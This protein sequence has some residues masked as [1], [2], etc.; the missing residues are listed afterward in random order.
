MRDEVQYMRNHKIRGE[1]MTR[2]SKHITFQAIRQEHNESF[3]AINDILPNTQV[4]KEKEA[5]TT[6]PMLHH[7]IFLTGGYTQ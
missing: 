2:V 1:K 6:N 7:K 4:E 3:I 5:T